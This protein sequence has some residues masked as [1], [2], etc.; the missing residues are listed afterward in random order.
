MSLP[1][2]RYLSNIAPKYTTLSQRRTLPTPGRGTT[3]NPAPRQKSM[4]ILICKT[5]MTS[6]I[7][8]SRGYEMSPEYQAAIGGRNATSVKATSA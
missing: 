4:P 8:R 3:K 7:G 6:W 5:R 2:M 1:V